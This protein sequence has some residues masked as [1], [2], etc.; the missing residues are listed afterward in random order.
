MDGLQVVI[1]R[2]AVVDVHVHAVHG[3]LAG[4][5]RPGEL[6]VLHNGG[7]G[8]SRWHLGTVLDVVLRHGLAGGSRILLDLGRASLSSTLPAG[9]QD[10]G[11]SQCFSRV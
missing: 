7:C 10:R 9:H 5:L 2:Q 11:N 6:L 1:V 8:R 4:F 3:G